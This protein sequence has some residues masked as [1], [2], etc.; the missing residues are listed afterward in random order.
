[1]AAVN[2][3]ATSTTLSL[4]HT[5]SLTTSDNEDHTFS[6]ILFPIKCE[7]ALPLDTLH[8]TSFSVRG[9]LGPM[10]IWKTKEPVPEAGSISAD[11]DLWEK[12]YDKTHPS[13]RKTLVP[14]TLSSPLILKPSETYGIYIHSSLPGDTAL[15]YDNYCGRGPI[16]TDPY[17]TLLSGHAH[18]SNR[19]FG[20][21]SMWGW[22]S[23]WRNGRCFVGKISYGCLYKLWNPW[24]YLSY[25]SKFRDVTTSLFILQRRTCIW[26][27]LPDE[28]IMY[29][30]N[31]CPFTW[32]DDTVSSLEDEKS[33]AREPVVQQNS[34]RNMRMQAE[35]YGEDSEDEDEEPDEEY[36][37]SDDDAAGSTTQTSGGEENGDGSTTILLDDLIAFLNNPEARGHPL[38][39]ALAAQFPQYVG[40]EE[41]EDEYVGNVHGEGDDMEELMEE[42]YEEVDDGVDVD[43]VLPPPPPSPPPPS[44]VWRQDSALRI[45]EEEMAMI[46]GEGGD[47]EEE[48]S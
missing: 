5:D 15:V 30:L 6:G 45:E 36:V 2:R 20:K 37:P 19:P 12:I 42:A 8:I 17:L 48:A 43:S 14:L 41:S 31:M 4:H 25:G 47:E 22:G 38:Y 40:D 34:S 33:L 10:T 29:I 28:V 3:P 35:Y 39:A 24:C 27:T 32:F 11:P 7:T 44:V 23:P 26:A 13:S 9:S 18:V 1:M 16:Y 21:T 46:E